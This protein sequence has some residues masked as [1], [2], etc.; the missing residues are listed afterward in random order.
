MRKV[1]NTGNWY[2]KW[3]F[4]CEKLNHV[5]ARPIGLLH[6]RNVKEFEVVS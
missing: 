3:G 1:T 2:Q 4:Y 5:V 6:S